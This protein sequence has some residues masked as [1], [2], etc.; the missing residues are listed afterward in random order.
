MTEEE[1]ALKEDINGNGIQASIHYELEIV[2]NPC[3]SIETYSN[4][5][6]IYWQFAAEYSVVGEIELPKDWREIGAV[7]Y[8]RVLEK[9]LLQHPRSLELHFW[10]S[11]FPYRHYF[12]EFTQMQCVR[13]IEEFGDDGSL[14]PYFFL[15][16]F[17]EKRYAKEKYELIK[18]CKTKPTA[19]N[20][21][22][23]SFN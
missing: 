10:R 1:L 11:Y 6:F 13:L 15:Y 8:P 3:A 5:A 16:L 20:L 2:N 22:I 19:K 7:R 21:Y 14:V 17:D 23:L 9:G 12:E 18:K 4:L